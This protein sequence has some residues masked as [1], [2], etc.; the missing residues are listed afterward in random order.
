M[1]QERERTLEEQ[2]GRM[3]EDLPELA[4]PISLAPRV[5]AAIAAGRQ[6]PWHQR[7]WQNW[8]LK[9]QVVSMALL[10][11][12]FGAVCFAAWRLTQAAG[13]VE[14]VQAIEEV[15]SRLAAVWNVVSALVWA[16]VLVVQQLGTPYVV[17]CIA[18]AVFGYLMC[19]ALG[20]LCIRL[21]SP[22]N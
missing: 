7:A 9:L 20:A 1:N 4:A 11:G 5:M 19:L 17:G 16:L 8:P 6:C 2:V 3:L 12:V 21:A 15:L 10:A 22:Q 13:Y 18:A 14:T